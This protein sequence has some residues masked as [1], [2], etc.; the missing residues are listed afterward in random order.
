MPKIPV[1][2]KN[3]DKDMKLFMAVKNEDDKS[4]FVKDA[5]AFYM[6]YRHLEYIIEGI[7]QKQKDKSLSSK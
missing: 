3:N 4:E 7:Y 6:R 5:I 1:S 2:F